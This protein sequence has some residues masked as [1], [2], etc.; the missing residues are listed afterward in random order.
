MKTLN[1]TKPSMHEFLAVTDGWRKDFHVDKLGVIV[2]QNK[3]MLTNVRFTNQSF[4]AIAKHSRGVENLPLAIQ[5]PSEIWS[6]WGDV[7][8]SI[9]MRN[10]ILFGSNI[11]YICTT[12]DGVI[13]DAQ[14]VTPSRANSFRKG[15]LLWKASG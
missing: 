4:H 8:Q 13:T 9:T 1:D 10:Y 5:T 2:F 3:E 11:T 15:L 12:K 7:Q 6:Y 14:G